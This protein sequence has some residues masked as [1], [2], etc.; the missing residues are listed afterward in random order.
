MLTIS[1]VL[2]WC[3]PSLH[4]PNQTEPSR[5]QTIVALKKN[6]IMPTNYSFRCLKKTKKNL[7]IVIRHLLWKL[8]QECEEFPVNQARMKVYSAL[9]HGTNNIYV[10]AMERFNL[11]KKATK[12]WCI[13]KWGRISPQTQ[14]LWCHVAPPLFCLPPPLVTPKLSEISSPCS[15]NI[16][17]LK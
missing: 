1:E 9:C 2:M 5:W 7:D 10:A 8:V 15:L 13:S 3:Y 4:Y 6:G 16:L 11:H 14:W 17:A 12:K